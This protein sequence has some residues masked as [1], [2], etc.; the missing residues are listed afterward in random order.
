MPTPMHIAQMPETT[1]DVNSNG[2]I[3]I[4]Q[5][6]DQI[7]DSFVYFPIEMAPKIAAE[8]LRLARENGVEASD[9]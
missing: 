9:G 7:E 5:K 2:Q 8:I 1:I 3:E 6:H 4:T